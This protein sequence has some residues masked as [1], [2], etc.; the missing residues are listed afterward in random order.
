[1]PW[2]DA[3]SNRSSLSRLPS[4]R[5]AACGLS[6]SAPLRRLDPDTRSESFAGSILAASIIDRSPLRLAPQHE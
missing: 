3:G 4:R 5:A 2:P 6:A 1:M